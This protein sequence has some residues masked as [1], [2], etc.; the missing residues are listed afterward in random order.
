MLVWYTRIDSLRTYLHDGSTSPDLDGTRP[1]ELAHGGLHV[2][3]R[4]PHEDEQDDVGHE[5]GAAAILIRQVGETPHV[6]DSDLEK[7]SDFGYIAW[8]NFANSVE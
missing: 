5:E 8:C 2:V 6:A 1:G 3:E 7:A 4:L